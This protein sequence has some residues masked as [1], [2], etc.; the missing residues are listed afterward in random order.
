[1]KDTFGRK[2]TY[3]RLSLTDRCNYRCLYCMPEEGVEKCA[4]RDICSF[5]ELLEMAEAS[6]RCG[7]RKIRL[8]GGEPLVRKGVADFCRR[9]KAI[10]GVEELCLTTNGSM[11]PLLAKPL[12]EAGVDRINISIDT[13]RPERFAAITRRGRLEDVLAGIRAAEDAGFPDIKLNVV[14][15]GGLNDDEI[16]DFVDLTREQPWTVRFIELMPIG[17]C[18]GWDKELFLP[19]K[20]VLE[21]CPEL[22][23]VDTHGVSW[24]YRLP[25][26]RGYVGLIAPLSHIFCSQC[27]RIRITADGKLKPCLHS[28][29]EIELRGL[30]GAALDAAIRRGI[31]F[32][33]EQHHLNEAGISESL[34]GMSAIG[35]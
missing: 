5:E 4:H 33:P 9:V 11:L 10:P 15:M 17:L 24:R 26:G 19:G 34:R 35:G 30:H 23:P 1:M 14:L 8:T 2:I 32:K 7:V 29:T 16:A 22:Q 18:A 6:V 12:R 27:S 25:G 21:R 20:A 13:L 31:A 28:K 3:L